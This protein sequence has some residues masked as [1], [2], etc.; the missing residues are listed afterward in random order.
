MVLILVMSMVV[1]AVAGS[2]E[3]ARRAVLGR[4]LEHALQELRT[5]Y[6]RNA[7]DLSSSGR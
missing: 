3:V 5:P 7:E 2:A 4:R 6:E 1:A